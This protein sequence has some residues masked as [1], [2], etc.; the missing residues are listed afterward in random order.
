MTS[1]IDREQ[2]SRLIRIERTIEELDQRQRMSRLDTVILL[3]HPIVLAGVT[4]LITLPYSSLIKTEVFS[5]RGGLLII[6]VSVS[7]F[8]L[9][10]VV[11]G[12]VEY[13][14]SYLAND[15]ARRVRSCRKLVWGLFG[16][17]FQLAALPIVPSLQY[18][19][20]HFSNDALAAFSIFWTIASGVC[21]RA[22]SGLVSKS[23]E[24]I[25]SW[26]EENV[27]RC[28]GGTGLS[29]GMY[30][31]EARSHFGRIKIDL[32]Y[33][34][35]LGTVEVIWAWFRGIRELAFLFL[36]LLLIGFIAAT[37]LAWRLS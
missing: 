31:L 9:C 17:A 33:G 22:W 26:M 21:I 37:V 32:S 13:I 29:S 23:S 35:M 36:F 27:P 10:G 11:L 16:M 24:K 30:A 12:F 14:L 7:F 6:V 18:V 4:A 1:T 15:V 25:T 34:C 28:L 3:L 19:G 5:L 2:S 8:F 20:T